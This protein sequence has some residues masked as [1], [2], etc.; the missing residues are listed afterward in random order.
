ML[1]NLR[2]RQLWA[3]LIN[4][5]HYT[6]KCWCCI[7]WQVHTPKV[8]TKKNNTWWNWPAVISAI[9]TDFKLFNGLLLL[10]A[11][12]LVECHNHGCEENTILDWCPSEGCHE[13]CS[14][15]VKHAFMLLSAAMY[16]IPC[17]KFTAQSLDWEKHKE[18]WKTSASTTT[19]NWEWDCRIM[20]PSLWT[21]FSN[22]HACWESFMTSYT[23]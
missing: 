8:T 6:Q 13:W 19:R 14:W 20:F 10:A 17:K 23:P 18:V 15:W 21:W 7:H 12:Y 3:Y 9:D 4:E 1:P 16:C 5:Q 2:C 11:F 22:D